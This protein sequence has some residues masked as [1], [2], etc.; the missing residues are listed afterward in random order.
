[1]ASVSNIGERN[2]F[3]IVEQGAS[4]GDQDQKVRLL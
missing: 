1:V 4:L 3:V 2:T